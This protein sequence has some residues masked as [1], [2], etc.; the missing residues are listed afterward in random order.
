MPL[1]TTTSIQIKANSVDVSASIDWTSVDLLMV[2]TKEVDSLKFNVKLYGS[3]Y[4]PVAS[5]QID[6]YETDSNGVTTHLF[7]G[8]I[9]QVETVTEG[10]LKIAQVTVTD[11]TYKMDGKLVTKAYTN[12]NPAD[13]VADIIANYCPAGFNASTF[14]QRP[15]YNLTSIKFNYVQP[16]KC[17]QKIA[18][19]IG[20]EWYVDA[21]KKIHFFL[22]QNNAAPFPIDDTTGG[23]EWQTIDVDVNLQNMKNSVF[24]IGGTQ[25][26]SFTPANEVDVYKGDGTRR[27]FQLRYAYTD[28]SASVA[29]N[30]A[31][32]TVGLANQVTNSGAFDCIYD[33]ANRTV[34]FTVAPPA[35]QTVEV[36][37]VANIP[38][39]AHA[40]DQA[41]ILAYGEFQ[42]AIFDSQIK[43]TAEAQ[44][45]A[46]A[47]ILLYGHAVYNIKFYTISPGI[48]VGQNIIFNSVKFGV[49]NYPLV[50]KRIEGRGNSS[51]RLR[52]Q[53][54]CVGS[55]TV[56]FVDIMS[57]LLQKQNAD[58]DAQLDNTTLE[59]LLGILEGLATVDALSQP[60]AKSPPYLY[61][62][63]AGNVG[64][65]NLS[66]WV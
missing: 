38:I 13:I 50:V 54:E 58:A 48:R 56:T 57:T 16:S 28:S 36:L 41:A 25:K 59:V 3:K 44:A 22:A 14:V 30:G 47:E 42:S 29:L 18:T 11:W 34:T 45:R 9:T 1:A 2:L 40:L 32:Q 21:D 65:F 62:A 24:V 33:K 46:Q 63:S 23:I 7:G 19:Q 6:F 10:L 35:G 26:L 37:G 51:K 53:V 61:G 8:N 39:V 49:S 64:V 5:D 17:L 66:T 20:W 31:T 55:D 15:N 52:Y 4:V 60:T 27:S 12:Q 43:T